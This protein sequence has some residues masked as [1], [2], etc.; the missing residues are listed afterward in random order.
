VWEHDLANSV[1]AVHLKLSTYYSKTYDK[2]GEANNWATVLD[3]S[4]KLELYKAPNFSSDKLD[5]YDNCSRIEVA[6]NYT[7]LQPPAKTLMPKPVSPH[8]MDLVDMAR[9]QQHVRARRLQEQTLVRSYLLIEQ[10]NHKD[11][12]A[13]WALHEGKYSGVLQMAKDILAVPVSGI[14]VERISS[15]A[16]QICNYQRNGLKVNTI[17]RP[18]MLHF[19]YES[20]TPANAPANDGEAE[21]DS[22]AQEQKKEKSRADFL[23]AARQDISD[24]ED[25]LGGAGDAGAGGGDEGGSSSVRGTRDTV[26]VRSLGCG[27]KSGK[28][29]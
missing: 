17:K 2:G 21:D 19:S 7:T 3:P 25:G 16:R 15:A 5:A 18:V 6:E 26:Q 4:H 24:N 12:L 8:D 13:L 29:A 11:P 28:R 10:T 27:R 20:V 1:V 22:A 23:I 14:G 9:T